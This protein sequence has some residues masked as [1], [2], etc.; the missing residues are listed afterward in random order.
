MRIF[1]VGLAMI[2]ATACT[3]STAI[4][5]ITP[6]DPVTERLNEITRA[7]KNSSYVSVGND[8][9]ETTDA[10]AHVVKETNHAWIKLT[11]THSREGRVVCEVGSAGTQLVDDLKRLP[12][13]SIRTLIKDYGCTA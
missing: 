5:T 13:R 12:S 6:S 10:V 8:T 11:I 2:A 7:L 4:P 3:P 1:F 9:W